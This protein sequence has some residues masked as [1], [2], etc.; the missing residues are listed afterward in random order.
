MKNNRRNSL[1]MMVTVLLLW[2]CVAQANAGTPLIWGEFLHLTGGNV[3]IGFM[4]GLLLYKLFKLEE[5]KMHRGNGFSQFLFRLDWF[6][7][8]ANIQRVCHSMDD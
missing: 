4:E 2:P 6:L 5:R 3:L 7:G 1:F 8:V